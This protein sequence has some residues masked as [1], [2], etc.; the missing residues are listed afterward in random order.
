[1]KAAPSAASNGTDAGT[2]PR[3]R[4]TAAYI[5]TSAALSCGWELGLNA[6]GRRRTTCRD[7]KAERAADE[8]NLAERQ[9]VSAKGR[10]QRANARDN[11][12]RP[13]RYGNADAER[14]DHDIRFSVVSILERVIP[15]IKDLHDGAGDTDRHNRGD[16]EPSDSHVT[17]V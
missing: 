7:R 10:R 5:A 14:R 15:L 11:G 13:D 4:E 9:C 3:S 1:M 6:Q 16:S 8:R 17:A 2:A 12:N